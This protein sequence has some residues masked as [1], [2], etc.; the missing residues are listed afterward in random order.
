MAAATVFSAPEKD[1]YNEYYH[2]YIAMV[3]AKD[4]L[5]V[6]TKQPQ[7]LRDVLGSLSA[8]EDS[9]LHEPYTWTLKQVL[10]HLLDTERIFSTRMMRIAIGDQAEQP[11]MDQN[12]Y[13]DN[14]D[15]ETV[16]MTD[17]LDE[18]EGIRRANVLLV[19]RIPA[20]QF[21]NRGVASES[22][23]SARACLFILAGHV[24]Y[25]L[26]IIHKRLGS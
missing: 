16:S 7:Q 13:V 8:G 5:D 18:F 2:N 17:L 25:H 19:K 24:K 3:D 20:E 26:E 22:E 11:G 4:F 12:V 10:G 14:L 23:I 21:A 1:E 9:K 6:F 15:Y